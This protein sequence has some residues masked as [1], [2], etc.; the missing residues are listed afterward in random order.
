MLPIKYTIMIALVAVTTLPGC[1]RVSRHVVPFEPVTEILHWSESKRFEKSSKPMRNST[2]PKKT[3]HVAYLVKLTGQKCTPKKWTEL[4][5]KSLRT[6][7][8]TRGAES[9]DDATYE[10]NDTLLRTGDIVHFARRLRGP[11]HGIIAERIAQHTFTGYTLVRGRITEIHINRK[12]G[13]LRRRNGHVINSF[14]RT[15][16]PTDKAAGYLAG[17]MVIGVSRPETGF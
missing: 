17:E 3:S 15:I 2:S 7:R 1:T 10:V 12:F 14:L 11:S 6:R 9:I 4:T 8:A 5:V 16:Q 13:H